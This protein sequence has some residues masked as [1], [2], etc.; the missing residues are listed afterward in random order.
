L[1]EAENG[2]QAAAATRRLRPRFGAPDGILAVSGGSCS[3]PAS[4][5][6]CP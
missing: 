4:P 3:S 6:P 1:G 2:E 5:W